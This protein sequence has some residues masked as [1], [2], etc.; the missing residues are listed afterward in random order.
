VEQETQIR[1]SLGAF[2]LESI[3]PFNCRVVG[4]VLLPFQFTKA[5]VE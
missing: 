3:P 4:R 5:I 1:G 2:E